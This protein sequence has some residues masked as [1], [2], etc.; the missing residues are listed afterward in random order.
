LIFGTK[1]AQEPSIL[2]DGY[3]NLSMSKT[4]LYC[5]S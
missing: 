5:K 4:D 1:F 3:R 2:I